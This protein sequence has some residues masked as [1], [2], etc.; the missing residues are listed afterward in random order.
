MALAGRHQSDEAKAQQRPVGWS[1]G[2]QVLGHEGAAHEGRSKGVD[3]GGGP[4]A[5][6]CR[7]RVG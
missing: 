5:K 7:Q 6:T 4:T 2:L 3:P 1:P